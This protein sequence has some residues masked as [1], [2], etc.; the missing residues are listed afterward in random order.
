MLPELS[1]IRWS[2]MKTGS[3]GPS[4]VRERPKSRPSNTA[5][6]SPCYDEQ[7]ARKMTARGAPRFACTPDLFPDLMAAAIQKRDIGAWAARNQIVT[8]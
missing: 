5:I 2:A 3:S 8:R 4:S 6:G 1:R 7:L